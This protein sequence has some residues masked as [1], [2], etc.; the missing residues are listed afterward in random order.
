MFSRLRSGAG[1]QPHRRSSHHLLFDPDTLHPPPLPQPAHVPARKR[2]DPQRTQT[3]WAP[4]KVQAVPAGN[5]GQN[6]PHLYQRCLQATSMSSISPARRGGVNRPLITTF[7][8]VPVMSSM[9]DK[10]AFST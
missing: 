4:T 6:P 10:H 9:L 1:D 5:P 3:Q 7:N 8:R 2:A